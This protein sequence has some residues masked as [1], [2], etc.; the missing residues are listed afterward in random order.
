MLGVCG[1]R[2]GREEGYVRRETAAP[3]GFFGPARLRSEGGTYRVQ[4][5]FFLSRFTLD[6]RQFEQAKT[7]GGKPLYMTL[8]GGGAPVSWLVW[9][10]AMGWLLLLLLRRPIEAAGVGE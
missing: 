7:R 8:M 10:V 6:P 1:E 4:A 3:S 2:C 5:G 9:V